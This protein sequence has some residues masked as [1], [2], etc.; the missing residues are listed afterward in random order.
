MGMP[1]ARVTDM[2]VCPTTNSDLRKMV[3]ERVVPRGP[4]LPAQR[5]SDH[6]AAAARPPGGHPP[7]GPP[8]RPEVLPQ[9]QP[10]ARSR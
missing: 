5:D 4:L 8:F 2:H 7:A 3:K 10:A 9:Q 1:Q 6:A